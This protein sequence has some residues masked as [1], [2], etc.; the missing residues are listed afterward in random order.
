[1][2]ELRLLLHFFAE[3]PDFVET[4][5]KTITKKSSCCY[6]YDNQKGADWHVFWIV[7]S[8]TFPTV[9]RALARIQKDVAFAQDK[10]TYSQSFKCLHVLQS[11]YVHL[12]HSQNWKVWHVWEAKYVNEDSPHSTFSIL[13]SPEGPTHIPTERTRHSF[14]THKSNQGSRNT[15][16]SG[17][18]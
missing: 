16:K 7:W 4:V 13:L 15:L 1:M 3:L 12:L 9:R 6:L 10:E 17:R 2:Q 18:I 14:D 8:H 5:T 11:Q